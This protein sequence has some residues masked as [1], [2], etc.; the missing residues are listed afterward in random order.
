MKS[1]KHG[2]GMKKLTAVILLIFAASVSSHAAAM[3]IRR[4]ATVEAIEMVMPSV[5]NI[6]TETVVERTDPFTEMFRQFY[7]HAQEDESQYSL[8]SG[9]VIDEDG[10]VLTNLHVVH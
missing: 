1:F 10:Y 9:V 2:D 8:G 3:D 6:R 5:V 7:G 4:D